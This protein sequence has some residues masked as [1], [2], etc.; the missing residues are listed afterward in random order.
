MPDQQDSRFQIRNARVTRVKSLPTVAFVSLY[1]NAGK[2]PSYFD[3]TV[4]PADCPV[5]EEGA[6]ITVN[7]SLSMRKPKPGERE[8]KLQLIA[9]E[10][11]AGEEAK[12]PKGKQER[13]PSKP[14]VL[15][16]S[17]PPF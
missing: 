15:D 1:A 14:P 6:V 9:R 11:Q 2:F 10:W 4:F 12:A 16:D 13:L 7:G 3:V 8:Y 5:P 17:E